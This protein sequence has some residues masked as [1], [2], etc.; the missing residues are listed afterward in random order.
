MRFP[1]KDSHGIW[2]E[3]EG[4]D[5]GNRQIRLEDIPLLLKQKFCVLVCVDLIYPNGISCSIP[6]EAQVPMMR[7]IHGLENVEMVRPAYGVEYDHID[8]RE[9]GG[10]RIFHFIIAYANGLGKPQPPSR[11]NE[12]RVFS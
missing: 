7:T 3:P 5:S 6:E 2:L 12:L 4:Y 1:H 9:L 10:K 11:R 8:P